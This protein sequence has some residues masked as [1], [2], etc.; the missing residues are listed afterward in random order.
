MFPR[1]QAIVPGQ[2]KSVRART[3]TKDFRH[4]Q[5]TVLGSRDDPSHA[6]QEARVPLRSPYVSGSVQL[7]QEPS[8]A[9]ATEDSASEQRSELHSH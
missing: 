1:H 2:E 8:S 3:G 5:M 4:S 9:K 6:D 7:L